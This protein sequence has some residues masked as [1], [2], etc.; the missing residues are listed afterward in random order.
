MATE[1]GKLTFESIT[2]VVE[3]NLLKQVNNDALQVNYAKA[4]VMSCRLWYKGSGGSSL[5]RPCSPGLIKH[6]TSL[7]IKTQAPYKILI[8]KHEAAIFLVSMG[9]S[10][11]VSTFK[12]KYTKAIAEERL[13][14][15]VATIGNKAT[16]NAT[17]YCTFA[18]WLYLEDFAYEPSLPPALLELIPTDWQCPDPETE[19]VNLPVI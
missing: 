19:G 1:N 9:H 12:K 4:M 10:I 14:R 2:Q 15:V 18:E 16:D 13:D 3:A 8:T 6:E 17:L 5:R 7:N 11:A